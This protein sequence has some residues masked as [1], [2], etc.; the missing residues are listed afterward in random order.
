MAD[1]QERLWIDMH[2]KHLE[3][4]QGVVTRMAGNSASLKNYCMTIAA[5]IIGLAAAIQKPEIL[6]YTAPLIIIFGVLD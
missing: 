3:M 5:A 2:M 6:Y 4:L 1:D